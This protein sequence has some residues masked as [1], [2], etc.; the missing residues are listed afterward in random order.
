MRGSPPGTTSTPSGRATSQATGRRSPARCQPRSTADL[1]PPTV[2]VTAPA[3]GATV[4]GQVTLSASA[5]DDIGVVGV[6]FRVD[7]VAVGAEDTS[8]PYSVAWSSSSVAN[9]SHAVT[10][11]ARDA[12]GRSTTS[13]SV[14]VTVANTGPSGLVGGWSFD[15]GAG[16]TAGDRSG[17]GNTGT[18]TGGP[19]W[20][21]SGRYGGALVFDGVNDLVTIPDA[22]SLDLTNQLTMAAWVRPTALGSWKQVLLKERPGGLAYALYA[23]GNASQ[24]PNATLT[25]GGDREVNAP[26]ALATN[27]WTH[28]AMTYDGAVMRLYVNGSQVATRNQTGSTVVSAGPLQIG[29]NTIWNSE[30]FTGAIDDVR[31]YNR[32]LTATEVVTVRDN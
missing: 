11:V 23:T 8:A 20:T 25:I 2:T 26:A 28:L 18:L 6:Q 21:T 12:A 15:E 1:E 24:R 14:T 31:L 10:A 5:T 7:G 19:S 4:S 29:G 9:G 27:T 13:A 32:A 30:W 22:A 17:R 3:G 16:P